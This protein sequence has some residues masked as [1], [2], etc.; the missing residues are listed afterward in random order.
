MGMHFS[1]KEEFNK[2]GDR[3]NGERTLAFGYGATV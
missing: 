2:A 1:N 3:G